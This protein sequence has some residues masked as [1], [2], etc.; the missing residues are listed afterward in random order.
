MRP[1]SL[2]AA[3]QPAG[4]ERAAGRPPPARQPRRDGRRQ[5]GEGNQRDDPADPPAQRLVA[6]LDGVRAGPDRHAL[7]DVVDRAHV[8][9]AAVDGRLPA[10]EVRVAQDQDARGAAPARGRP[11]A[12]RSA[13]RSSRCRRGRRRRVGRRTP[14][15]RSSVI[16]SRRG[17]EAGAGH[18]RQRGVVAAHDALG[19]DD[20]GAGHRAGDP[21]HARVGSLVG[22]RQPRDLER[23]V[24]DEAVERRGVGPH[25]RRAQDVAHAEQAQR[26]QRARRDLAEAQRDVEEALGD[27]RAGGDLAAP[28]PVVAPDDR[29][30]VAA[31]LVDAEVH[32]DDVLGDLVGA[33]EARRPLALEEADRAGPGQLGDVAVD[34]RVEAHA[35]A[36]QVGA[37]QRDGQRRERARAHAPAE[38]QEEQREP[39]CG[40]GQPHDQRGE[41]DLRRSLDVAVGARRVGEQPGDLERPAQRAQAGLAARRRRRSR[42]RPAARRPPRARA[43]PRAPAVRSR[44]VSSSSPQPASSAS[45]KTVSTARRVLWPELKTGRRVTTCTNGGTPRTTASHRPPNSATATRVERRAH[46]QRRGAEHQRQ[47]PDV[48]ACSRAGCAAR[49]SGSACP[50]SRAG[51]WPARPWRAGGG[52]WT[53]PRG[54]AGRPTARRARAAARG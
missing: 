5:P 25:R 42:A 36:E 50:S 51:R 49:G 3:V 24:G 48:E 14:G 13:R 2:I 22:R 16:A 4:S 35:G 45:A 19:A 23:R 34:R 6:E 38:A 44:E 15:T 37:R 43:A 20:P 33:G 54:R 26:A 8:D 29:Q 18:R 52:R 7:E 47:R 31:R 11:R 1:L 32:R 10:G 27:R 41:R 30:V 9:L 53:R 21:V 40:E 12:R 17:V 28:Q 39:R 46:E